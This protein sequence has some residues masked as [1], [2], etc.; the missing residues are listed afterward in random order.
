MRKKKDLL[1]ALNK[2]LNL[3]E[4][5]IVR[6]GPYCRAYIA[7]SELSQAEKKEAESILSVL[8]SDSA[9]HKRVVEGLIKDLETGEK[10][11]HQKDTI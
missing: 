9:K 11:G 3:E 1:T 5:F 4:D 7:S 10:D 6:L 2:G 8:E